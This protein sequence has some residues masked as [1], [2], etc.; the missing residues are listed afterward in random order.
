MRNSK[1]KSEGKQYSIEEIERDL[2][3]SSEASLASLMAEYAEGKGREL[4]AEFEA[5][6]ANGDV[7]EVPEALDRKCQEIIAQALETGRQAA[8]L[9]FEGQV[10]SKLQGRGEKTYSTQEV[11]E[12]VW[13][14]LHSPEE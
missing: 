6:M 8:M 9:S 14:V 7:P 11:M 10:G 13:D 2:E 1:D 5:A 12:M 4:M 3:I